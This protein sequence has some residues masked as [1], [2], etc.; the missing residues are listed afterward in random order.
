MRKK[1]KLK[2]VTRRI[3]AFALGSV[4]AVTGAF[5]DFTLPGAA[6]RA[7]AAGTVTEETV[8]TDI[9]N[10]AMKYLGYGYSQSSRFGSDG[11][12]DCSGLVKTVLEEAGFSGVPNDTADWKS[13][14]SSGALSLSYNG[15]YKDSVGFNGIK[16]ASSLEELYQM[17]DDDANNGYAIITKTAITTDRLQDADLP[18]GSIVV[19][20]ATS[21]SAAHAMIVIGDYSKQMPAGTTSTNFW[22][23]YWTYYDKVVGKMADDYPNLQSRLSGGRFIGSPS[24]YSSRYSTNFTAAQIMDW[25]SGTAFASR[26]SYWMMLNSTAALTA[27]TATLGSGTWIIDAA[28]TTY[29]VR[30]TNKIGGK[31][32]ATV[33]A[34][35]ITW[36][37]NKEYSAP[38]NF[39]KT[40]Q[41]GR[42][43]SGAEFTV[44]S[45]E[46]CT[47]KAA[48][49]DYSAG[50][51]YSWTAQ[52][53]SSEAGPEK[54]YYIKE[55]KVPDGYTADT[56]SSGQ[57]AMW[58]V[59]LDGQFHTTTYYKRYGTSGSWTKVKDGAANTYYLNVLNQQKEA[60]VN[61]S[62]HKTDDAGKAIKGVTFTIYGSFDSDTGKLGSVLGTVTTDSRGEGTFSYELGTNVYS[63]QPMYIKETKVPDGY[64]IS[65]DVVFIQPIVG[66]YQ[67]STYYYGILRAGYYTYNSDKSYTL[68]TSDKEEVFTLAGISEVVNYPE[69]NPTM[70]AGSY[71][72]SME[73]GNDRVTDFYAYKTVGENTSLDN[74]TSVTY[75]LY[76]TSSRYTTPMRVG[77]EKT[78]TDKTGAQKFRVDWTDLP[79]Y[80][81]YGNVYTYYA[82][83][84]K[85]NGSAADLANYKVT[86][87]GDSGYTVVTNTLNTL[88]GSFTLK[89]TDDI[90]NP[91]AA[92][93]NVYSSAGC[94]DASKLGSF[95]TANGSG[96]YTL[97]SWKASEGQTKTVYFKEANLDGNGYVTIN[98]VKYRGDTNV[99]RVVVTGTVS[100]GTASPYKIYNNA[101]GEE[102]TGKTIVN[103]ETVKHTFTKKFGAGTESYIDSV[104]VQLMQ[105]SKVY[106]EQTIEKT[107]AGTI[108]YTWD[109]LPKYDASGNEY[110][111][112]VR[113][114]AVNGSADLLSRFTVTTTNDGSSVM[115]STT[116]TNTIRTVEHTFYKKFGNTDSQSAVTSIKVQLYQNGVKYGS[117]VTVTAASM[118]GQTAWAYKWGSLPQYDKAGNA[119]KYHVEETAVTYKTADGTSR[120]L[121]GSAISAY[122]NTSTS[123][124]GATVMTSTIITNT[125]IQLYGAVSVEKVNAENET[126]K[127]AGVKYG[128]Y[129][130]PECTEQIGNYLTTDTS[131][132]AVYTVASP[133]YKINGTAKTVYIKEYSTVSPYILD[134]T[135]YKVVITGSA[136]SASD[137]S[138]AV[139]A[140]G[141]N[142]GT[143]IRQFKQDNAEQYGQITVSKYGE[144]LTGF[145]GTALTGSDGI[146]TG[147]TNGTFTYENRKMAG[148]TFKLYA[149]GSISNKAGTITYTDGQ[150]IAV[151]TTDAS[152]VIVF[153]GLPM[154]TYRIVEVQAPAGQTIPAV[155][156][157]TKTLTYA[158]QT[159]AITSESQEVNDALSNAEV[160]VEKIDEETKK[161]LGNTYFGLYAAED[162]VNAAGTKVVSADQLVAAVKTD[163]NG[164]GKFDIDIPY[165]S[166][167]VKE[168]QTRDG[169]ILSNEV[170]E[171]TFAFESQ[172]TYLKTFMHTFTD[173]RM[174][175]HIQLQKVDEKTGLPIAEGDGSLDGA[176]YG[177]YARE[178]IIHPDG[179]SGIVY[180]AGTQVAELTTENGGKASISGLYPGKY[181]VQELKPS[182]GYLLDTRKY[183]LTV[184]SDGVNHATTDITI[185]KNT[186]EITDASD[187]PEY[188]IERPFQLIKVEGSLGDSELSALNGAGFTVYLAATL[189]YKED[190]SV[191]Y[192][193]SPRTVIGQNGETE[194]FTD[195]L[196]DE[197]GN[198][199]TSGYLKT[200]AI[201]YGKYLVHE[202]TV[203]ENMKQAQ[204]FYVTIGVKDAAVF[205]QNGNPIQNNPEPKPLNYVYDAAFEAMI[206]VIKRDKATGQDVALAGTAFKIYDM[207]DQAYVVQTTITDGKKVQTDTFVT[208]DEGYLITPETLHYGTYRIEEQTAP[209]GYYNSETAE[210]IISA[211]TI[212]VGTGF[213]FE[214]SNVDEYYDADLGCYV[215]PVV[216]Y[217]EQVRGEIEVYKEGEVLDSYNQET[218]TFT[219]I[220]TA[221][222][223]AEY[224][225]YADGPV[226][227]PDNQKDENGNRKLIY[228]DG[229]LVGHITT[230]ADGHG[231]LKDLPLG[232]YKIVETKAPDGYLLG[233]AQATAQYAT[234][235]YAGQNAKVVYDSDGTANSFFNERPQADI[236]IVKYEKNEDG[237]TNYNIKLSGTTFDFITMA[238]IK[239]YKGEV[240]VQAGTVLTSVTTGAEGVAAVD[241]AINIP[242]GSYAFVETA[243]TPGYVLDATPI[244]VSFAY[245]DENTPVIS[246][247]AEHAND[248]IRLDISKLDIANSKEI[249][250]AQMAV[251]KVNGDGT[252]T[253]IDEWIS[254]SEAHR[255]NRIPAGNYILREA[256]APTEHGYVMA[257][258][259]PFTVTETAIVQ[260][261]VMYDDHTELHIS[262][263][264]LTTGEPVIGATLQLINA[265]GNIY[266]EWITDGTDYVLEYIPVGTYTLREI[267]P[268]EG[269][270]T[271]EAVTVVVEETGRLVKIQKAEMK[272]QPLTVKIKKTDFV[273]GK[274]VIGAALQLISAD[275]T[276][277]A[278]WI[279][280][281]TENPDIEIDEET[282]ETYLLI[283]HI[284]AGTYT[285]REIQAPD[286][287]E[288]A[289]DV[290]V[291]IRD[292]EDIQTAHMT[293]YRTPEAKTTA[294]DAETG[295]HSMSCRENAVLKDTVSYKYLIPGKEYTVTGTVIVKETGEP[296]T[297]ED[298]NII[299]STTTFVPESKVDGSIELEFVIDTTVLQG[300]TLVVF[301]NIEKDGKTIIIHADIDDEEQ[302]VYIP[303]IG[304]TF[305]DDTTNE[306]LAAYGEKVSLTDVIAYKNLVPGD[307]YTISGVLYSKQTGEPLLDAEGNPYTASK[308][309]IADTANGT[310]A[311]TFT[312]NTTVLQGQTLVSFESLTTNNVEIAVEADIKNEGQ[313]VYVPEIGTT[314][315]DCTTGTHDTL[316]AEE[317]TVQDVVEYRG[318]IPGKE[319]VLTGTLYLKST[320]EPLLDEEGNPY[321]ATKT[322][323]AEKEN[324]TETLNFTV[325]TKKIAGE[326]IVAFE[327]LTY[328][329]VEIAV[330]ADLEDADQTIEVPKAGKIVV[331]KKGNIV[332]GTQEAET[333][334]GTVNKLTIGF[335]Y[336]AGVEFTVYADKECTEIVTK[337]VTNSDGLA[338][339][340]DLVEGIYYIMETYTP[341]GYAKDDTVYT[342]VID[343]IAE[344]V[345]GIE[346]VL[347]VTKDIVNHLC[348]STLNIYKVGTDM[349]GTEKAIP[350]E[351][352]YFGVCA[353]EDIKN[354]LSD[355]VI[356]AGDC[357]AIIK[358][359]SEGIATMTEN[360]PS[361][362][363]YYKEIRTLDDFVLD[364]TEYRFEVSLENDDVVIDINKTNPLINHA[365]NGT[366]TVHKVDQDGNPLGAGAEFLLTCVET[367]ETW[368][369]VTD[370]N[371]AA[372]ISGLPIGY[373]ENGEWVY[374]TYTL[375][376]T[377]TLDNYRLDDTVYTFSFT[378]ES[379]DADAVY[380]SFTV[381]NVILGI[382]DYSMAGGIAMLL[383]AIGLII[384]ALKRR[385]EEQIEA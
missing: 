114:T 165:G 269:Y 233:D 155:H 198:L 103:Y 235:A 38:I 253:I 348:S 75:Q 205:D 20:E 72:L 301:E 63:S 360:L 322:F 249:E 70:C 74:I 346:Y 247:R 275:G 236:S 117:E 340:E 93:F 100:A 240:I 307:T 294:K 338:V 306:H 232:N 281:D 287:F 384:M 257:Q 17:K 326:K 321:T 217:D 71:E 304:T 24:T 343:G 97:S 212:N 61:L 182:E 150:E 45:N 229:E 283:T 295:T 201:P 83:E 156:E 311:L 361:G 202:S 284:P 6:I 319:Y 289:E 297:D 274:E 19:T 54:T 102:L 192:E 178:D 21:S 132:V 89:K 67:N 358:T 134:D 28:S 44:Y 184:V 122:F 243:V 177:L 107:S 40:N 84:T 286:G 80:D 206:K 280:G 272:D 379:T 172:E 185:Y 215:L 22:E 169:Y 91:V 309:F 312:I 101:T 159:A 245:A 377:K 1:S 163:S 81:I 99:Y 231:Y 116:I 378:A 82:A 64:V 49:L 160:S 119:Y 23:N 127:I 144:V 265:A 254:A 344:N 90:G 256:T 305:T 164:T 293:D 142:V 239:N 369:L 290:T 341:A 166:Y 271:A 381:R 110:K 292:T 199:L 26:Q 197:N 14:I 48:T 32:G 168:L 303:E 219:W 333:K 323:I 296:L 345:E 300:Q 153:T 270:A 149:V 374:Y 250:G 317:V 85:V 66:Y 368:T 98:G 334:Y 152:G 258:D 221:L 183:D 148:A 350:L 37:E 121:T 248:F 30:I 191:D 181:Y 18:A 104:T 86:Y 188:P 383:S 342:A 15:Q 227:T 128:V 193:K 130:D 126:V 261:Q 327:S 357:I 359:N 118:V 314:F 146:I 352:V 120:T 135:V 354:I 157:W 237:S 108:S 310:V 291:T 224:N 230:G 329:G 353:D 211:V 39:H 111:Y 13:Q 371:G 51:K 331:M 175:G 5:A 29:G 154:G 78:S 170:Y 147:Y 3:T 124:A 140:D 195:D 59:E 171:F 186:K 382:E 145:S 69:S 109:S 328:Q 133:W 47:S 46:A 141:E 366:L 180:A 362:K 187:T 268:A 16:Y 115:T 112:W 105:G 216:Y 313:T 10:I 106:D 161:G 222:A 351:G 285:L 273:T 246:V 204:D 173:E 356:R 25:P 355:V 139:T 370:G 58:K 167:Y 36:P 252:E 189:V 9:V 315:T 158:G 57:A 123:N 260:E 194:L 174:S 68:K 31:G 76:R 176:V 349:E 242:F 302:T 318:L 2:D 138:C 113:E 373:I 214:G 52:W 267:I 210:G 288:I 8:G 56:N 347:D 262:K 60:T 251:I 94:T 209:D 207:D 218:K 136:V 298:G 372:G 73:V 11:T 208:N 339:S 226:Y 365:K 223:G 137:S 225:V 241:T 279:T 95:A 213:V 88:H 282:G 4:M 228:A 255:I 50:G 367:G 325:N 335:T 276:I 238:D 12:F 179:H 330:E 277:Y 143:S 92:V 385:K 43:V 324:G 234:L 220:R 375:Q 259:L 364:E 162:I 278:E 55:T 35:V 196:Y 244:P 41:N 42:N 62:F 264:D 96:T 7:E 337:I 87:D 320:G 363:Y 33:P 316:F 376:E 203:P 79:Y 380:R 77:A 34:Y 53:S 200:I 129:A 131:G 151:L 65:N 266:A 336:L 190:G 332:T 263:T 308:T 27:T 125:L 299:T